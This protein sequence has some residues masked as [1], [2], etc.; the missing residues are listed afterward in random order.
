M[1]LLLNW[2]SIFLEVVYNVIVSEV[3]YSKNFRDL[4]ISQGV[5]SGF[6][7]EFYC[8]RC[9]D[10]WRT[11]F[12]A[13]R[14]AQ[15]SS[16]LDKAAGLFGGTLRTLDV[17]AQAVSQAGYGSA[18][19]E[20]FAGAVK[21]AENHFHRCPKCLHHVCDPCWDVSKGLCLNCA[22]SVAVAASAARA[23][24][25]V[26]SVTSS[27]SDLGRQA[28]E[29]EVIAEV[30]QLVCPSCKAE[31]H[32]AK[33]CPSCG[34]KLLLDKTCDGCHAVIPPGAKFCPDCGKQV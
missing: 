20:A 2:R 8:D 31:T 9:N 34:Q 11:D 12:L 21:A 32:G 22:P 16:W 13:Y 30:A 27:A 4:S 26:A 14:N 10:A 19:N 23:Q 29:K 17:A 15:A 28:G 33:F 24:G 6:Q 1:Y 3:K 5:G 18:H 25:E 7:F